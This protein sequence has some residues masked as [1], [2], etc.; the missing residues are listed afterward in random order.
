MI[1]RMR[2]LSIAAGFLS[3]ALMPVLALADDQTPIDGRFQAYG[4][5]VALPP[6]GTALFWL[7]LIPLTVITV[8]GLF[9]NAR[10]SHLD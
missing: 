2:R 8:G 9:K 4:Q 6:G 10:R 3:V 7:L 1:E 5:T